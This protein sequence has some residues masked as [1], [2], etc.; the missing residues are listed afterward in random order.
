MEKKESALVGKHYLMKQA[1][2][3][4]ELHEREAVCTRTDPPPCMAACPLGI[5][6]RSV[7]DHAAKGDFS[8]AAGIIR[9]STPFL[10]TLSGNCGGECENRC[11]LSRLGDGVRLRALERACAM[12]GGSGAVSRFML[13]KKQKKTAVIGDDLFALACCWELGK[14]GYEVSWH[15]SCGSLVEPLLRLGLPEA[16]AK[17]DLTALQ[18]LRILRKEKKALSIEL[19]EKVSEEADAVC[20]SPDPGL[21]CQKENC[22]AGR[23]EE[24]VAGLLASA[25]RTALLADCFLQGAGTPRK[26]KT[27]RA[28]SL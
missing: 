21:A 26:K 20:I 14:K 9:M 6:M 1:F 22:F 10:Y 8:K 25:K 17:A 18:N 5:D 19:I 4:D 16:E 28:G 15:T 27:E 7:C 24:S 12:Y 23:K 2:G 13:P 11:T 3:Q